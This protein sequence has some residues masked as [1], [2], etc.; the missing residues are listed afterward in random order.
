MRPTPSVG[1]YSDRVRARVMQRVLRASLLSILVPGP[2]ALADS[3][4]PKAS[5]P[6]PKAVPVA[7]KDVVPESTSSTVAH[8]GPQYASGLSA[9]AGSLGDLGTVLMPGGKFEA[10][11]VVSPLSVASTIGLLQAG[12]KGQTATELLGVLDTGASQ[13]RRT[14]EQLPLLLAQLRENKDPT[15]KPLMSMAQ[16][17]WVDQ[18][19]TETAA[20]SF[21]SLA[22][23]VWGSDGAVLS[24]ASAEAA[25]GTINQWVATQTQQHIPSLLP[26]GSI[27]SNTRFVATNA[28][29]FKARWAQPFDAKLTQSA[30]FSTASGVPIQ[31]PTMQAER[32]VRWVRKSTGQ[33]W[34][35]LPFEGGQFA[36][37][38]YMPKTGEPLKKGLLNMG[39]MGLAEMRAE[40]E[41]RE[42]QFRLPK[43]K[44]TGQAVALKSIMRSV[45]VVQA[46]SD[47][48]DFSGIVGKKSDVK[49]DEMFHTAT[50]EIDESGGEATAAT[51]AVAVAKGFS[52]PKMVCAVDRPFLFA[53]MHLP[54]GAPLFIGQ[55]VNPT[56]R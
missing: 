36:L 44:L 49:L 16:R 22:K 47:G 3:P 39:G 23:D 30:P 32:T 8:G 20:P 12:A 9:L 46:F 34:A 25:R 45:G 26:A 13:G 10:N 55:V 54:T 38:M 31:A 41:D 21:L 2:L 56:E 33:V 14:R 40:L 11:G 5:A 43:F 28:V 29:H 42:C 35:E 1:R 51:A 6:A 7:A 52:S 37:F 48:A 19:V 15:G 17:V 27:S 53:L 50:F 24:F 4:I 18:R